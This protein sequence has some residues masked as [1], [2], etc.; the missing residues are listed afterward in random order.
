MG[1]NIDI[2]G[3]VLSV[4]SVIHWGVLECI[5]CRYVG[6]AVHIFQDVKGYSL[7]EDGLFLQILIGKVHARGNGIKLHQEGFRL[8]GKNFL[9][10]DFL[11]C[12]P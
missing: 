2:E 12:S 3:S 9:T 4:V 10:D 1:K 8:D 7:L 11:S 5:P 6:T